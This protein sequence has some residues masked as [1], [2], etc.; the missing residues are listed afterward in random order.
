[1]SPPANGTDAKNVQL[2][3]DLKA[4][5]DRSLVFLIVILACALNMLVQSSIPIARGQKS[6]QFLTNWCHQLSLTRLDATSK[7]YKKVV[8]ELVLLV[9]FGLS[10][11]VIYFIPF[12]NNFAKVS[13]RTFYY[14]RSHSLFFIS[15]ALCNGISHS[16]SPA[17]CK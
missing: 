16:G 11:V 9:L 1:M 4:M 7:V 17:I 3:I 8:I 6:A 14:I 10:I 2:A 5:V 13:F 12:E 15:I